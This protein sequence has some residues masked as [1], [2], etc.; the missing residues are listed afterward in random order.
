[1]PL[2]LSLTFASA[3]SAAGVPA[4]FQG[5]WVPARSACDSPLRLTVGA[6]RITLANGGDR[7]SLGGIEM[8]GPGYFPPGYAGIMA[9]LITEFDGQQPATM[10]FN[11]NEKKGAVLI[12]FAPLMPG[13]PT[14]QLTTYNARIGKLGLAKRFPIDK[15]AL[16]RCA[17]TA[18]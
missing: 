14:P 3:A 7:E 17:A 15:V 10:T 4:T 8:A 2:L 16:K 5:T 1:L 6:D 18:G 12:E 9:V 13:K 11:A